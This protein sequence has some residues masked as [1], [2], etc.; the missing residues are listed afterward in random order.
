MLP[1]LK[2]ALETKAWTKGLPFAKQPEVQYIKPDQISTIIDT[3]GGLVNVQD[4]TPM[5]LANIALD[6]VGNDTAVAST[7]N[8]L[9]RGLRA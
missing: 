6:L 8:R 7:M 5:A 1:D 4:V 3:T 9:F 2:K